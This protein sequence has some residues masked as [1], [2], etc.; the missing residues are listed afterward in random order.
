MHKHKKPCFLLTPTGDS[1]CIL[2]L[3]MNSYVVHGIHC[4]TWVQFLTRLSALSVGR[5]CL[6]AGRVKAI[7]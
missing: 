1:A 7:V 2:R 6:S 3:C 4:Y 5:S